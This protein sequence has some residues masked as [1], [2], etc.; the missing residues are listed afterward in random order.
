MA[1]T[2]TVAQSQPKRKTQRRCGYEALPAWG[3]SEKGYLEINR[4]TV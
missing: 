2:L 1:E 3:R 4:T